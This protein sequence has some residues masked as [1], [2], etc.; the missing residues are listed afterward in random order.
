M[1]A[2]SH[3]LD[4]IH[5][6]ASLLTIGTFDG[7]HRGHQLIIHSLVEQARALQQPAVVVTFHPHP[8]LVLSGRQ[9]SYYLTLP[10]QRAALLSDLGV[11]YVITYPFSMDTVQLSAEQF[12]SRLHHHLHF[13]RLVVGHDFALGKDREGNASR[14]AELGE[15]YRYTLERVPAVTL[16]G[17]KVSSSLI[18]ELLE[19]GE[20]ERA[21]EYLG[22]PFSLSGE[23][24][25]G[26]RRGKS[27]G[28]PTSNL[29]IPG[30]MVSLRSGVYAC[31]AEVENQQWQAVTN[32]GYRPT[33]GM[34][35]G[36]AHVEAHLLGFSKDIYGEQVGLDFI[37]RLRDEKR[38][39]GVGELQ[40]QISQDIAKAKQILQDV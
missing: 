10:E 28:F 30:E 9:Q 20:V 13:T 1:A 33:F 15:K 6:P 21:A 34:N 29:D 12:I 4:H 39:N 35:E 14:L 2:H 16:H 11:D 5:L 25:V 40:D 18:R 19:A 23:V 32:I 3:S 22:R 7:V 27:L 31:F 17:K 8:A 36:R 24:V 26:D 37:S 38:F